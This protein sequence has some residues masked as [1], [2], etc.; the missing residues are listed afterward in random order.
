MAA[1]YGYIRIGISTPR[2]NWEFAN[3]GLINDEFPMPCENSIDMAYLMEIMAWLDS[4]PDLY[5]TS[6]LYAEG[7][8]QNSMFS[9]YL[10]FCFHARFRGVF[11]SGSGMALHGKLKTFCIQCERYNIRFLSERSYPYFCCS[12]FWY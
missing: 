5:D 10:G 9:A 3:D 8:S 12:E 4:N 6:R 11:Q 7:H 1:R 2:G